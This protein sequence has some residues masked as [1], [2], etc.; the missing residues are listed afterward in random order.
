MRSRAAIATCWRGSG[1]DT[2]EPMTGV[3][4]DRRTQRVAGL[5]WFSYLEASVALLA[6]PCGSTAYLTGNK[7]LE[8]LAVLLG[9]V[10]TTM[11]ISR[12]L[13]HPE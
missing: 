4:S 11:A 5:R 1:F 13:L 2:L 3:S 10:A 6:L 9:A 8:F 12:H 7:I